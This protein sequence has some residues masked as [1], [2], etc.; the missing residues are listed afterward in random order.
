[1]SIRQFTAAF[2]YYCAI[3]APQSFSAEQAPLFD[4]GAGILSDAMQ[5][6]DA[7]AALTAGPNGKTLMIVTGREHQW[8]GVTLKAPGGHWNLSPFE[9]VLIDVKNAGLERLRVHCRIDGPGSQAEHYSS[10]DAV[11]LEPG[12]TGTIS[13]ELRRRVPA[14]LAKKL[15]GMRGYP[16]GYRADQGINVCNV[17]QMIVFVSNSSVGQVF[18]VRGIRASG[19]APAPPPLPEDESKLFPL[20]D[21]YGQYIHASWP[22]KTLS[23]D[24][25]KRSLEQE[26]RDLESHPGPADWN[27]YGGWATGPQLPATGF[28]RADKYQGKW[29]LVDPEGRLFWSHGVDC[30]GAGYGSTPVTDRE[31]YFQDLPGRDSSLARFH[32]RGAGAPLG[33]YKDKEYDTFS[34]DGANLM[35]KYGEDYQRQFN[36]AAHRRLRSWGMNTIGNWSCRGI[37]SMKKTPYVTSIGSGGRRLE[38]SK[39][40][41]GKFPDVFD[42]GFAEA[43]NKQMEAHRGFSAGDPWCI[44]Y[45]IDN[46][47]GWGDACSL[48]EATLASPPDQ[49]AKTAFIGDLKAKYGTIEALNHAWGVAHESWESLLKCQ[50]PPYREKARDELTA[51]YI[52]TAEQYFRICREAVKRVAPRQLYLGCRFASAISWDNDA[53][54]RAAAKH[55]DV[56]SFNPY[57]RGVADQRLPPGVDVPVM[58]GEFHFGALDRGLFHPGLVQTA[59]QNERAAAYANYVREALANPA[60]VGAHWFQ[61]TDEPTTGRWDGENYQI[62]LVDICDNPYTETIQAVRGAG[63]AMYQ[64]R[65]RSEAKLQ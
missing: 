56:M 62:G 22:G 42:P 26:R 10:T 58:I 19:K 64:H 20:I 57:C 3:I 15:V 17:N 59:E 25:L 44:G 43:V 52:R 36:E 50:T 18:E 40:H 34:F 49:I 30:V 12:E 46:E 48:A 37:C 35:R 29:W 28:F 8:P 31:H 5:T 39:G 24:D 47:L 45:F 27:Q 53:V 63:A 60:V 2:L 1:M 7:R 4:F 41:W 6:S 16:G 11:A 9:R 65:M 55:C 38:G 14:D 54:L 32:G 13:V 33:Y 51:F 61:F 21:R 23:D